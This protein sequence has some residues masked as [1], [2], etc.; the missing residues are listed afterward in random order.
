MEYSLKIKDREDS[1][2]ERTSKFPHD[3]LVLQL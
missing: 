2:G 1:P 3:G